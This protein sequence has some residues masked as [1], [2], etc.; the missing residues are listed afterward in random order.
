M[1]Q[2]AIPERETLEIEFKSDRGPLSDDDLE[3]MVK[4]GEIVLHGQRK[5]AHYTLPLVEPNL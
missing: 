5:A 2:R 3:R 1:T 4:A